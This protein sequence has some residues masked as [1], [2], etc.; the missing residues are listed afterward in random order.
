MK[1]LFLISSVTI[2]LILSGCATK[3]VPEYDG[4]TY[5]EIKTYK[6]GIVKS[7]RPVV[8]SDNGT[9]TF[10]GAIVGTVLGS[11]VGEGNGNTLATLAGGLGGAYA[12]NQVAKANASELSV[13]L[14]NG[15]NIVVVVKGKD[16]LVGD[17]VKIIKDGNKVDQVYKI[18]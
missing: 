5:Q 15:K 12:G 3:N 18:N 2:M 14:N 7:V 10:L 4:N 6:I 16:F 8:I 9:G 1:K 13:Q 17:R 11:M